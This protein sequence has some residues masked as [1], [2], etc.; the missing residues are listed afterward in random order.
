MKSPWKTDNPE[1]DIKVNLT[2]RRCEDM[3]WTGLRS[4]SGSSTYFT[5]AVLEFWVLLKR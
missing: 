5:L 2:D 3:S 1:G 4:A